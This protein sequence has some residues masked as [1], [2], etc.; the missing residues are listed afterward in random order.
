[1]KLKT[2]LAT[3]LLFVFV[4]FTSLGVV[5]VYMTGSQY[6][7]LRE[8][9]KAE[10][11]T[12]VASLAKDI[13]VLSGRHSES[14]EFEES[15]RNLINSYARY[16]QKNNIS[17]KFGNVSDMS[18][19]PKTELS[20]AQ[21]GEK[22]LLLI[23]GTL[24]EPFQY[25]YLNYSCDI[26][27]NLS[28][29]AHIQNILLMLAVI[30]SAI[31]AVV[32]YI[33]LLGIFR[34]LEIVS[35]SSRKIADG[36]YHERIHIKGRNEVSLMAENFNRM[37]MEIEKQVCLLKEEAS[38]KQ[39]FIDNFA[40]EIR[41]PLTS[42]YGYAEYMQKALLSEEEIIESAQAILN[43]AGYMR[44]ISDSLLELAMLRRYTLCRQKVSLP[45]LLDSVV[46]SLR[47][48][49]PEKM[50]EIVC[51]CE[52]DV[53]LGQEDLLRSLL[54]NLGGNAI[55]ACPAVGGVIRFEAKE[56]DG[57]TVISVTDNGCGISEEN[58]SKVT[59][60]FYRVDKARSRQTG[61][62][63]LGLALCKQIVSVHGA[64]MQIDSKPGHG[65][66]VELIF[67]AS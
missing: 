56:K 39:Q 24:P 16:Y 38:Q 31:T 2:F 15:V 26:T 46:Q 45:P 53:L 23:S 33:I 11:E 51:V 9:S 3:Y 65:T 48:L 54:L 22:R 27:Q 40:H 60:P 58:I 18:E 50:A 36:Q 55:K 37:A 4:C 67:T 34:P 25:Y 41:T 14:P 66:R 7:M 10:Y 59:E 43:E 32:L 8:K 28:D 21:Q 13:A 19:E 42:V 64:Q 30:F 5:S 1:M 12:I 17:L 57:H 63:G 52:I 62:V 47:S 61:G 35:H 29:L 20:F 49:M 6:N 44:K